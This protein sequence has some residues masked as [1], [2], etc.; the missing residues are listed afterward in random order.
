MNKMKAINIIADGTS[1]FDF[2][3]DMFEMHNM[4]KQQRSGLILT[5]STN[6]VLSLLA[7]G[8]SFYQTESIKKEIREYGHKKE[9]EHW[10]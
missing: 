3:L 4:K 9:V 7:V 1:V 6:A 2:V 10:G 5:I 8:V